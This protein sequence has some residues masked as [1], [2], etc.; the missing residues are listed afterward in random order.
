MLR[1]WLIGILIASGI[2]FVVPLVYVQLTV[3]EVYRQ[4]AEATVQG[5][6]SNIVEL[7]V[8]HNYRKEGRRVA[9]V[10]RPIIF[11]RDAIGDQP[12][13][14]TIISRGY[15]TDFA[16]LPW[17]ARLFFSPFESYAE[18]A[19]LHDWLYAIGEPGQKKQADQLFLRAMLDDGVSPIV[20]RYFYTA[21]RLGTLFDGGGY[22]R[23][24]EWSEAFYATALEVDFPEVCVPDRPARAFT[25]ATSILGVSDDLTRLGP[26]FANAYVAVM[27]QGFDPMSSQWIDRLNSEACQTLLGDAMITRAET[28]Y[29]GLFSR[30]DGSLRAEI[31]DTVINS[32]AIGTQSDV[33]ARGVY[34]RLYLDAYLLVRF[35]ERSPD[36]LWCLNLSTR[37]HIL[38]DV[39]Y[40][41][42]S[43]L[44]WPDIQCAV[45]EGQASVLPSEDAQSEKTE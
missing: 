36:E 31:E 6:T 27:L 20:A 44:T 11:I 19:V 3:P 17:L 8:I 12:L 40:G 35:G 42:S 7:A 43:D 10:Q 30:A 28:D 38:S 22:G 15:K 23:D 21:V 24:S 2:L 1:R 32:V 18:A 25:D 41:P 34:S 16:S 45:V 37:G 29:D 13:E 4:P 9:V 26:D 14:F 5:R 39:L 33:F